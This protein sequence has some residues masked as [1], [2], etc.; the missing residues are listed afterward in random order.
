MKVLR[1]AFFMS[2]FTCFACT[3]FF[4]CKVSQESAV[5]TRVKKPFELA[6]DEILFEQEDFSIDLS[7]ASLFSFWDTEPDSG[8]PCGEY[9]PETKILNIDTRWKAA[10]LRAW[11]FAKKSVFDA[12]NY[13]Y[14]KI[15]YENACENP[16]KCEEFR[17]QVLYQ[18]GSSKLQ[19]CERKRKTQYYRLKKNSK[20]AVK[21]IQIW[22]INEAP[23]VYKIHSISFTQN[24][25]LE[26]ITPIVDSGTKK[27]FSQISAAELV[28]NMGL[29]WNLGN[30]F[31]AH[32]FGWQENYW[33]RGIE[34]E[35]DWEADETTKELLKLPYDNG[36][37]T[38]RIPV[39]WFNHIIDD[40]Y[41]ID[42]AWMSRVKEVVDM[43]IDVG[44]Y[45]ILNEHHSVH[46]D[47]ETA[48]KTQSGKE[49]EYEKRR[50]NSPLE[51]A[52]GYIVSSN[53]KDQIE[54]KKF[55]TKI[56]TQIGNAFNN[57][58]DEK[59]I[60][61]TMN[62]P[63]NC[64]D[65]HSGKSHE[66]EPALRLPWHKRDGATIGGYWCDNRECSLCK[67]EYEVLNEYNQICLDSIRATGG[68]NQKRFVMI[69]GLC[70]GVETVLPKIEDE[71]RGIFTP[72]LFKMPVDSANAFEASDLSGGRLLLTV[73]KYPQWKLD[74]NTEGIFQ[75]RMKNDISY[76]LEE[77]NKAFVQKGI[78]VVIGETGTS[79]TS[80]SLSEREKWITHLLT[81]AK[82]Y[83]MSVVWWDC[84]K[85]ASSGAE[86]NRSKIEFYEPDFV[87]LMTD[88][89]NGGEQ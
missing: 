73:H 84:G 62:E 89:M 70:T 78:P 58:Y 7:D 71:E 46:G 22:K 80:V 11:Q 18:D 55:L 72:G 76:L 31:D 17:I 24:K 61:E 69:P 87:K 77:L 21:E 40:N 5:E 28:K 51:Y 50:M 44:Y 67:K 30:T 39:T 19:I 53:K 82:K 65:E 35:F 34:S 29:G 86:I 88:I 25:A 59:L 14:L 23:M 49:N 20:S 37:K 3:V 41:T 63:R 1:L 9:D 83:N 56:W 26:D 32:S 6:E 13:R 16:E 66:W 81:E 85:S 48:F 68:N 57:S 52:D 64:R 33:E 75:E 38:I 4:C 10:V 42:P 54:S 8:I 47:M 27:E 79:K 2:F 45:V 74:E 36:Y 60:F 12:S 15:E 43:A